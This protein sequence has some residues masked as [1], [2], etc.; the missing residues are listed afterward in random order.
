MLKCSNPVM[1]K[2][3]DSCYKIPDASPMTKVV[4]EENVLTIAE[5]LS[6]GKM[7][8]VKE[9]GQPASDD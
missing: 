2:S 6:I 9:N 1:H 5:L 8:N 3:Y 7:V 4:P